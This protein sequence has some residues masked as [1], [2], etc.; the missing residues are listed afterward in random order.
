MQFK[1]KRNY[2][3]YNVQRPYKRTVG[4]MINTQQT[5]SKI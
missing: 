1:E 2:I 3:K 5:D 4:T